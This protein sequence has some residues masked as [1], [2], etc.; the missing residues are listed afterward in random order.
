MIL[1]KWIWFWY[2]WRWRWC[3]EGIRNG[4]PHKYT[5]AKRWICCKYDCFTFVSSRKS[6]VRKIMNENI[7]NIFQKNVLKCRFG[8]FKCQ[9][10]NQTNTLCWFG[11]LTRTTSQ[12]CNSSEIQNLLFQEWTNNKQTWQL[13]LTTCCTGLWKKLSIAVFKKFS[14]LLPIVFHL[15]FKLL[16]N[17][18][19]VKTN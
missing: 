12:H 15:K 19:D 3:E 8:N 5:N 4:T 16:Q 7:L 17:D 2:W 9:I 1:L 18:F 11:F 6:S 10:L 14:K 13:L